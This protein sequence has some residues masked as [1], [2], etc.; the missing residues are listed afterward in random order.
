MAFTLL[1]GVFHLPIFSPMDSDFWSF[2]PCA[3]QWT[4]SL[5]MCHP[6]FFSFLKCLICNVANSNKLVHYR[7]TL[8]TN[9]VNLHLI[10]YS[11][12]IFFPA[13]LKKKSGR[14]KNSGDVEPANPF[15]LQKLVG[16]EDFAFPA[17]LTLH[18]FL[19]LGR[20]GVLWFGLQMAK[21]MIVPLGFINQAFGLVGNTF[22]EDWC[23][24]FFLNSTVH[25]AL[26]IY[27]WNKSC[28]SCLRK[29]IYW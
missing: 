5:F 14:I 22:W 6:A 29:E 18:D 16:I 19:F 1:C 2:T 17:H 4:A 26:L 12:F 21:W 8:W 28:A 13:D 15:C 3:Y 24:C 9:S 25:F 20:K 27:L 11:V 7:I 10:I 23:Q